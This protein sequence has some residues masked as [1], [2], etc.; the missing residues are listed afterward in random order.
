MLE[1]IQSIF[2]V[3]GNHIIV[4]PSELGNIMK[5]LSTTSQFI[6]KTMDLHDIYV[7]YNC[8]TEMLA[9]E[10]HLRH[11]ESERKYLSFTIASILHCMNMRVVVISSSVTSLHL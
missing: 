1:T 7:K 11:I 2:H 10:I 3:I 4:T 5:Y 8:Y 6:K 9:N